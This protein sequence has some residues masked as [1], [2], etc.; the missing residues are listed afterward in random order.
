MDDTTPP[1]NAKR[2]QTARNAAIWYGEDGYEPAKTGLNG[3]RMAGSSFLDGFLRHAA[4]DELVSLVGSPAEEAA[5]SARLAA[6]G[7]RLAHR[8]VNK[9]NLH[10]IAPV[11]TL[12]YASPR[13]DALCW[14]RLSLGARAFSISG[15][16]H[17]TDTRG[18]MKC[19]FDLR[20]SPQ[21]EWDG[22]VCTSRAVHAATVRNIELADD[23]LRE[24]F[25][26]RMPARPQMP[27]IPLGIHCDD[28]RPDPAERHELRAEFG[29]SEDDIV[30]LTVARLLPYGKFDP[31]PLFIALQRAQERLGTAKRLH[32]LACGFYGPEMNRKIFE[33]CARALMPDVGYRQIDGAAPAQRHRALSGADIFAFAIDNTQETFGL[34]PVEAMAAGLPVVASDWDGLRDTVT[35]EVGIR[36]PTRSVPAGCTLPESLGYLAG[37]LSYAQYGNRLSSMVEIDLAAMT[38]AF[39]TLASDA[40][41]RRR[42]GAA[43]QRRARQVYDWAAVIPQLQDFWQELSRIRTAALPPR[44]AAPWLRNPVAPLPMDLFA[45]YPSGTF[46]DTGACFVAA[47]TPERLHRIWQLRRHDGI[48]NPFESLKTLDTVLRAVAGRGPAGTSP[49]RLAQELRLNA[50]TLTRCWLFLL[51]FGLIRP[52]EPAPSPPGQTPMPPSSPPMPGT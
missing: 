11:G 47:A 2:P 34:A 51:K 17:T 48:G 43:G 50:D 40:D 21:M 7:R 12:C 32:F 14:Q 36:V 24:R 30:V 27:V 3:R 35:P 28:F 29:W 42:M 22:I 1:A 10:R 45:A 39:V 9:G 13:Y 4:I 38:Q 31:A 23:F 41:L 6:S 8:T 44:R 46:A 49:A 37:R 5:I 18:I 16:T 20:A 26:G 25:G 15:I 52:A 33:D 19:W